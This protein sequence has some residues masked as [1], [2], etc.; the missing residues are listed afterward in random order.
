MKNEDDFS[1]ENDNGKED[2]GKFNLVK[3]V[4]EMLIYFVA[5]IIIFLLLQHFV[6]QHIEVKGSSMENTLSNKDHLILEKVTYRFKEPE[7]F[8]IV[9]FRP[10]A[11]EEET[12]YIKRVIGL[13]G[14]KIQ[15]I[16]G[17]VFINDEVL[18]DSYASELVANPGIASREILLN[19]DEYFLI[20]DNRNNSTDSRSS[21][22]GPVKRKAIVGRAWARIWPVN[23]I[24]ILAH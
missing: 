9:V 6:G 3:E 19:K 5:I 23:E 13:P 12:Y 10:Y 22:I 16:N 17:E 1:K 20:G 4:L 8:E 2:E 7:R 18:E 24:E 15:I 11:E 21:K 14:E